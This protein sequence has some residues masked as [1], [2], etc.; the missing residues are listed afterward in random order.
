MSG[1][2]MLEPP[3][4]G[5]L[6]PT[7]LKVIRGAPT[8]EELAVVTLLLTTLAAAGEEPE[9]R[10]RPAAAAWDRPVGRSPV[11]WPAFG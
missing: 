8:A 5:P 1:A 4:E 11:S 7:L 3:L 10:S 2:K 6:G 9:P